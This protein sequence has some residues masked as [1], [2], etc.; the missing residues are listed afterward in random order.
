VAS[1]LLAKVVEVNIQAGQRVQAGEVLVRLDDA[2]LQARLRQAEAAVSGKEADQAQARIEFERVDRLYQQNNASK[3]EWE[4][5]DTALKTT[6]AD[7][8]RARES[9]SEAQTLAAYATVASP[10]DGVVVDKHVDV[11]DTASP[12]QVLVTL[13][14]PTR[15]QLIARVRESL[16]HRLAVGQDIGVQ[17]ETL[18]KTCSGRISEIV[19]EAESASRTFSVKVTGPCPPGVYSGMFGRL[20]I[21]LADEEVLLIPQPAVRRIGQLDIVEDADPPQP[22]Q[23]PAQRRLW[24]RAVRL[25]RTFGDEVEVLAGLVAGEEVAVPAASAPPTSAPTTCTTQPGGSGF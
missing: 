10:I 24:R 16:A 7:L 17:I 25:G 4:R 19:P 3:L 8:D 9:R 21:P 13:Y 23:A 1:K 12:G 22:G 6:T 20:L 11:G 5:A 14:D 18:A 15:M 2:D